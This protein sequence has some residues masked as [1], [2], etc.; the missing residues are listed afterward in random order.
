[1]FAFDQETAKIRIASR[2]AREFNEMS[3]VA[4]RK[5]VV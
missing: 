5:S 2:I 4:D 3:E 1:M